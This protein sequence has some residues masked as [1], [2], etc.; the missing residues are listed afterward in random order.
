[1]T[2]PAVPKRFDKTHYEIPDLY[3][4]Q[5]YVAYRVLDKIHEWM[6]CADVSK[7][8]PLRCTLVGQGGT[9]KSVLIL[10]IVSVLRRCFNLNNVVQVAAPTGTSAFNV[11][12][13]TCHSLSKQGVNQGDYVPNTASKSRTEA[14]SAVLKDILCL[15]F[16]ERSMIPSRLLG[17]TEMI[18]SETAYE[19]CGKRDCS[20]AGIPVVMVSGDDYQLPGVTKGALDCHPLFAIYSPSKPTNRGNQL[21]RE[22]AET[23][24]KLPVVRRI[25]DNKTRDKDLV[26]RVRLG[27]AVTKQDCAKI[28]SLKL[29]A[30]K[31][32]HGDNAVD[33][34]KKKSI[35]LFFTNEKRINHN[36][37][38]LCKTNTEEH[39]TAV[40]KSQSTS[41]KNGKGVRYH[42]QDSISKTSLMCVGSQVCIDGRN[43]FP[44]WGLHNGACGR[45]DEIVFKPGD[46][47]N[48]GHLCKYV[49][50]DFPLYRGPS[51]DKNNPTHVPIPV[52]EQ[53]CKWHCC[54]RHYV[55]LD[56]CFAR[57]IHKYQGLGAGPPE[58]G[59][60]PH[61]YEC[62]VCDPG[63][64][65]AERTNV[66]L[67][68][69]ALSR[70]TTLG[71][72]DGLNSAIYFD[73][74]D[75]TEDRIMN[76]TRCKS[77][78]QEY[79]QVTKRRTWVAHLESNVNGAPDKPHR[80]WKKV[81]DFFK[82][83][84]AYD[85]LYNRR[86]LYTNN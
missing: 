40:F 1:M 24:F 50:V 63:D 35:F 16:D 11:Y 71:D 81:F 67:F 46:N 55:P 7:F 42:F 58:K 39:P 60:L 59:K 48:H 49:V 34:I 43:F 70:A 17:N 85:D 6:T 26:D 47:P 19:T 25:Q 21:Y 38:T 79:V 51:W 61:A 62:I 80:S 33:E 75:L 65:K 9:G 44:M 13:V 29:K 32:K 45:V 10:T 23:V 2:A 41:V 30:I 73:G 12:G 84:V 22:L 8:V 53:K 78:D 20:F 69:T 56:L 77:R 37:K 54:T 4:D 31:D 52:C 68:Y 57:T 18:V 14:L 76:L 86:C 3:L 5:Q 72:D 82:R 15:I 74:N 27:D 83:P 64:R 66:G 36:I 28:L